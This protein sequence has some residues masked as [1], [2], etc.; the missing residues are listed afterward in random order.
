MDKDMFVYIT[1][2]KINNMKYIGRHIG[3]I[4]YKYLGLGA[5]LVKDIIKYGKEN[6]DREILEIV[7]NKKDLDIAEKFWIKKHNAVEDNKYYNLMEGGLGGNS[8]KN[9][10]YSE[11]KNRSYKISNTFNN[12]NEDK[13]ASNSANKSKAQIEVRK[14]KDLEIHRIKKFKD[15]FKNKDVELIEIQYNKISGGDNYGAIKVITPKGE[16]NCAKDASK[17]FNVCN[18][19]VLNRCRSDKFPKWRFI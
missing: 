1:T 11:L 19:T 3:N 6:F 14:R 10:S 7:E 18:G 5:K 12:Y 13:R 15:T 16:F 8:L 9:L 2:N 4:N 17:V